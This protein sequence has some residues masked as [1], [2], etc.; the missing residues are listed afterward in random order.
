MQRFV[1]DV[2]HFALSKRTLD[3]AFQK[4]LLD[5]VIRE[6]ISPAGLHNGVEE[7]SPWEN[8]PRYYEHPHSSHDLLSF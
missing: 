2:V 5:E 3:F 6:K 1:A 4:G 8:V 7:L